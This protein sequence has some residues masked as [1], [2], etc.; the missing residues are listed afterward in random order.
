MFSFLRAQLQAK[1][2]ELLQLQRA[3]PSL[4]AP[5]LEQIDTLMDA[6]RSVQLSTQ[7]GSFVF[8]SSSGFDEVSSTRS[9]SVYSTGLESIKNLPTSVWL[10]PSSST[11]E[12]TRQGAS[13]F[14]HLLVLPINAY[15]ASSW[16]ST[17]QPS[18][19]TGNKMVHQLPMMS[20]LLF[21]PLNAFKSPLTTTTTTTPTPTTPPP[22]VEMKNTK[23][24]YVNLSI[25]FINDIQYLL[26]FLDRT[27][28]HQHKQA[29]V[30][31]IRE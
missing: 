1:E 10:S 2:K 12:Q 13:I 14:N 22:P 30:L 17:F 21:M 15:L 8:A 27:T 31:S 18:T 25:Y 24:P 16:P 28:L 6:I 11:K 26:P 23:T 3:D 9:P 7:D 20:H 5:E 19:K 4:L 29:K